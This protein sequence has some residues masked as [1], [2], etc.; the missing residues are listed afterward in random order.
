MS[1]HR[2]VLLISPYVKRNYV[3]HVNTTLTDESC[4]G[5]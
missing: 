2:T 1:T 4:S 3:S 5:C